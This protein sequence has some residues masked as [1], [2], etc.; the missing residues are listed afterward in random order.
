MVELALVAVRA[1]LL[2]RARLRVRRQAVLGPSQEDVKS[3]PVSAERVV[4]RHKP[5]KE[6]RVDTFKIIILNSIT[7]ECRNPKNA[8]RRTNA[9]SVIRH[10]NFGHS[11][12]SVHS[13]FGHFG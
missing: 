13:D 5:G 8:Q 11:G 2:V 9:G 12:H 3:W 7:V 4:G 6:S 10:S 1:F